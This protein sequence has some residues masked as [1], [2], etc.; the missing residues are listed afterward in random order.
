MT[1]KRQKKDTQHYTKQHKKTND[2]AIRRVTA[3]LYPGIKKL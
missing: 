3:P 2:L 1:N